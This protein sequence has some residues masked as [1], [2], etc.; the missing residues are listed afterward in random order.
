M[1][2]TNYNAFGAPSSANARPNRYTF[3]GYQYDSTSA[4]YYAG[5]RYYDSTTGRFLSEDPVRAIN[6]YPYAG[7]DPVNMVDLLGMQAAG[8]YATLLRTQEN[9]AKCIS[10]AVQAVAIPAFE[11][12]GFAL[13]GGVPTAEDV[14]TSIIERLAV[15]SV[16]C[17]I[18]QAAWSWRGRAAVIAGQQIGQ[19]LARRRGLHAPDI[20]GGIYKQLENYALNEVI[21]WAWKHIPQPIQDSIIN[22]SLPRFPRTPVRPTPQEQFFLSL[23]SST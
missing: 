18:G 12:V 23:G 16:R 4:L 22:S 21:D 6:P 8:E 17:S 19:H 20:S 3:T 10:G 2:A 9:N 1:A 13:I 11:A 7:N 14:D 5:A 15:N